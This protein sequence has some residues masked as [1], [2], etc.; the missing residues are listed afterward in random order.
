MDEESTSAATEYAFDTRHLRR[1]FSEPSSHPVLAAEGATH[2]VRH[3]NAAFLRLAGANRSDLIGRPFAQAV[4]RGQ[5]NGCLPLLDRVYHTGTPECLAEQK[6]GETPPAYWSYAVWPIHGRDEHPSGVIIQ[7]ADSTETA[8]FRRQAA[9]MN[10]SLLLSVI[11]QQELAEA[12]ESLSARLET[13]L[14]ERE[15]FIAAVS[16]EL[17]T[18]LTPVLLAASM[19]QQD[20]RLDEDTRGIMQ[21]IHRNI[22]LEARLIDDLLDMTRIER[23]KLKMERRPV[24]LREVLERAVEVCRADMELGELT[25]EV[26]NRGGTQFVE[27]DLDQVHASRGPRAR[28]LT[29]RRGL[30]R[31]GSQR[32]WRR[33]GCRFPPQGVHR[34]RARWKDPGPQ[35]GARI[36]ACYLQD[37]RGD[38]R[39]R[40]HRQE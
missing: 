7:V 40:H 14:R 17:R 30:M 20:E 32:Q 39:R 28:P 35:G 16:H 36:G 15:Y 33:D 29:P 27:A 4:P 24:G 18:P 1:Y 22:T 31:R 2:V 10:E 6:H 26:D 25:L 12:A 38:A 23:S 3:A 5:G 8:V 19:L 37:D 21:M 13:A 11:R 9:A 34:L